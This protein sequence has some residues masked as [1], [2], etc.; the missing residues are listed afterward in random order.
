MSLFSFSDVQ[1][2]KATGYRSKRQNVAK[3]RPNSTQQKDINDLHGLRFVQTDRIDAL[4][5]KG[6]IAS[7]SGN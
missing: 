1:N 6:K 3:K 5:G 4:T 7:D 2:T